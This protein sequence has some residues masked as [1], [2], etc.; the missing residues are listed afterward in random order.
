[1]GLSICRSIVEAHGGR[2]RAAPNAPR[3]A[4][5]CMMLPVGKKALE[6]LESAGS[7]FRLKAECDRPYHSRR[8]LMSGWGRVSRAPSEDDGV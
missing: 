5:F 1:M 6:N 8:P 4:V 2:L 7:Q 3:G